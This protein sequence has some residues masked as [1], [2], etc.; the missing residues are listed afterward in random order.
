MLRSEKETKL[1]SWCP[2]TGERQE[3]HE[4]DGVYVCSNCGRTLPKLKTVN[5]RSPISAEV[6]SETN[7]STQS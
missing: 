2:C 6:T 4:K 3:F 5:F 1:W 7:R